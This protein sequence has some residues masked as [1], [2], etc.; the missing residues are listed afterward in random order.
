VLVLELSDA[1]VMV[2]VDGVVQKPSGHELMIE[3]TGAHRVRVQARGYAQFDRTLSVADGERVRVPVA[4]VRA[5]ARKDLN[6]LV[7][8]FK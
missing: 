2:M 4:L 1:R 3:G 6:Y 7:D 8:P 5:R